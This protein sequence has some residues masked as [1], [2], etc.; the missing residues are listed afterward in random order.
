[1]ANKERYRVAVIGHTG[2]GNYG[3]GLDTVWRD[4][5]NTT[6]VAVADP[7]ADGLA[8]AQKR[9][10][11]DIQGFAD[12]R[13]LLEEVKPDLVSIAPRWLDQHASMVLA[14]AQ[15]GVKG[16]YLEKPLCRDLL[17][18]DAMVQACE[19]HDTKVAIA[20]Q[21]RYSPILQVIN[22]MIDDDAIGEPLEFR[23]RGKE[24]RRG[25][26]EDLWVLGSHIMNLIHHLG[27]APEWCSARVCQDRKPVSKADVYS[28]NEGIGPLAGNRLTAMYGLESG[29]TAYF[30]SWRHQG[31]NPSRFGLQIFGSKGVIELHEVGYVPKVFWLPDAA[32]SPGRS[33][34]EWIPVTSQGPGK[35]ETIQGQGHHLGNVAACVDLIRAIE[36]DVQPEASLY[37]GRTTVEMIA[38]VFESH[39]LGRTV[40]IPLESRANPLSIL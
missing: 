40:E 14:A 33:G 35:P 11:P 38:A 24:D 9:L 36:G 22:D 7:H 5:P 26:G 37:E 17:E 12:Y 13:K 25:G 27:G 39:R 2:R 30:G 19:E 6:V 28:G 32:W 15:A 29:A 10:G 20:F 23:G 1:M 21:T 16:I 31:G 18:A 4:V 8:A 34:K 3:H